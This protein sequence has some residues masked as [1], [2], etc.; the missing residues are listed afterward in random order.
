M[1]KHKTFL[2]KYTKIY[3]KRNNVYN[4]CLHKLYFK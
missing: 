1:L 3:Y 4:Y 2:N